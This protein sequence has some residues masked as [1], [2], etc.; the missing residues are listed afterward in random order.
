MWTIV[1]FDL[2]VEQADLQKKYRNFR[3]TLS[4]NGF[5]PTQKS[6]FERW[7]ENAE[8]ATSLSRK[9]IQA[10]PEK[11]NVQIMFMPDCAYQRTVIFEDGIRI[12]GK[13]PPDPWSIY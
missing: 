2:P 13:S 6:V 7:T 8:K 12:D 9:I 4:E 5:Q 11:G 10:V 3:K 1:I